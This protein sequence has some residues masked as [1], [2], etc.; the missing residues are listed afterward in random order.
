MAIDP[1]SLIYLLHLSHKVKPNRVFF[2][3][4]NSTISPLLQPNELVI[5][6]LLPKHQIISSQ[7]WV[8]WDKDLDNEPLKGMSLERVRVEEFENQK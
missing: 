1:P 2:S 5:S 3:F 4:P 6:E 8:W 7:L